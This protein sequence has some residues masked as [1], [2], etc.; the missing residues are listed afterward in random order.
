[1][2]GVLLL[3]LL[4]LHRDKWYEH[5]FHA[6]AAMLEGV[7]VI[8]HIIVVIVRV[9]E[10]IVIL[11][12]DISRADVWRRQKGSLRC[13]DF[14]HLLLVVTE[15]LAQFVAQIGVGVLVAN[16]LYRIVHPDAAMVSSDDYLGVSLGYLL[17]EF[18]DRRIDKP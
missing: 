17:E 7:L 2:S 14:I 10:E 12:K 16:H 5:L 6:D 11:S 1:M 8:A 9:G 4:A 18:A 3:F 15:V 13:F